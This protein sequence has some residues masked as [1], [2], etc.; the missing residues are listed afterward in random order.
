MPEGATGGRLLVRSVVTCAG[1]AGFRRPAVRFSK[2]LYLAFVAGELGRSRRRS[3][4]AGRYNPCYVQ[5]APPGSRSAQLA[6]VEARD[7]KHESTATGLDSGGL[8]RTS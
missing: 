1:S 8:M 2:G 6:P 5:R 7:C 3:R 4:V